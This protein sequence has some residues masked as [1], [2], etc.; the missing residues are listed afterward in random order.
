VEDKF[1]YDEYV[2]HKKNI[3]IYPILLVSDRIFEI[4][5]MNYILNKW[6]LELVK[7][8]LGDKYN[9]NFIRDL[10]FVDMDTL[11]YWLPHLKEKDS[12]FRK[13]I[14]KHHRGMNFQK[15]IN[16]PNLKNGR[17]QANAYFHHKLSPVSNRFSEYK[18]P[19][20]LM[21]DKF[22]DVLSEE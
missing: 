21:V 5:G 19:R 20:E 10:T 8:K 18:F 1:P 2:N 12:N 22:R 17:E 4:L 13:I 7:E 3:T 16:N 6:Y 9:R 14:E 15:K 11:I